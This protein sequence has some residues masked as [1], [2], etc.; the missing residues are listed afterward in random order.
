MAAGY[1]DA[2]TLKFLTALTLNNDRE[3]FEQ[4]KADYEAIVREPALRLIRD[5]APTLKHISTH[6]LAVD[7]K[8][9]GS[10]MRVQ[11]DTRFAA[12][13]T[14]YKTNIGIQFRHEVGKDV[15]APGL[16]IHIAP[17][18]CFLGSGIW[19]PDADTLARIRQRIVD[20]PKLWF[21]AS[22]ASPFRKRFDLGGDSL[23]R[24]PRGVDA[25]HPAL[26]DLKRKDHIAAAALSVRDISSP[27]LIELLYERFSL[28][29]PYLR[30]LCD[31]LELPF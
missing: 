22:T 29:K 7:K 21:K 1:F 16:Y 17:D 4:H 14:P 8:V 2:K 26:G 10:L 31:A 6:F 30:F 3:W 23:A 18:E 12:D 13:K 9:G 19:H 28:T 11:R 27:K 24:P 25:D 20:K 5:F 15:H